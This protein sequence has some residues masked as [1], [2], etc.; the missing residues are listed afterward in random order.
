[1]NLAGDVG[2]EVRA[3]DR[4]LIRPGKREKRGSRR[5]SF[6]MGPLRIEAVN[7]SEVAFAFR[8][9]DEVVQSV[10]GETARY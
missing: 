7:F 10:A 2:D 4:E 9:G 8:L 3:V 1:V 5:A 6:L